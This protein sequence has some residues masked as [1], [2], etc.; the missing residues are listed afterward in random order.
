MGQTTVTQQEGQVT[1]EERNAFQTTCAYQVSNLDGLFWYQ[2]KK[3]EASHLVLYQAS[4]G[5]KQSGH[6][7]TLLNTTEKYSL[8]RL[9]EV[10]VSDSVLYLCAVQDTLVQGVSLA[11]QRVSLA[12]QQPRGGR[13]CACALFPECTQRS[14][15]YYILPEGAS[16]SGLRGRRK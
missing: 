11:V 6:L 5:P 7:T 8:L 15:G 9:E 2:Q 12:V 13:G 3:G 4:A 14:A 10:E 1:V 16:V